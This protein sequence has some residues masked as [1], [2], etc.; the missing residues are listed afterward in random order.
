MSVPTFAGSWQS[1]ATGCWYQNDDGTYPI[2]CW[3]WIDN[4]N[5]GIAENYYFNEKGYILV[6]TTTSD[7]YTVDANGA[8]IIDGVVQTQTSTTVG[9]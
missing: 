5:D 6:S 7:G 9:E 3:Q 4:N 1:D 2:N 8:W